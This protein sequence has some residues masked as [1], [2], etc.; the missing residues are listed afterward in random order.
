M[1]GQL[2]GSYRS[3]QSHFH[4]VQPVRKPFGAR[5]AYGA[6]ADLI[7]QRERQPGNEVRRSDEAADTG[8]PD[9]VLG[10]QHVGHESQ[11]M[12]PGMLPDPAELRDF[13]DDLDACA[14]FM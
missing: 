7:A 9:V 6:L 8:R 13:G 2:G 1:A 4:G 10:I 3:P 5:W 11:P 14:G 12:Q